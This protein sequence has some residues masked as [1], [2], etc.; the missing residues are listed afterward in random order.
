MFSK[1]GLSGHP[2]K[3]WPRSMNCVAEEV[4][5]TSLM[6]LRLCSL[7]LFE[8]LKVCENALS[9]MRLLIILSYLHYA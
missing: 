8:L 2:F 4:K 7:V 1:G 5:N 3:D 9:S 6:M